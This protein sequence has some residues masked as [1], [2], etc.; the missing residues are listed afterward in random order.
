MLE[1]PIFLICSERAGSNLIRTIMN[2]HSH[3]YAPM[4]LHLIRII[5]KN[6]FQYG[7]LN[8]DKNWET[9]IKHTTLIIQNQVGKL[10]IEITVEELLN[11]I[12]QRTFQNIFEY[13]YAKGLK[14]HGKKRLFLKENQCY[15]FLYFLIHYFPD[16]K[17]VFQVRDP[18]DVVLS[19]KKSPLHGGIIDAINVWRNDQSASLEA[20]YTLTSQKIFVQRYEDLLENSEDVLKHLCSFLEIP[21]EDQ[22]LEF[23]QTPQSKQSAS[24]SIAWGNLQKPLLKD[25]YGKFKDGLITVEILLIEHQLRD[26][27]QQFG[28]K[29]TTE[30]TSIRVKVL[31]RLSKT[32]LQEYVNKYFQL[33][34]Q[35]QEV[36]KDE[37]DRRKKIAAI[38]QQISSEKKM[39]KKQGIFP[40]EEEHNR[41][42]AVKYHII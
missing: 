30:R 38:Y 29:V 9:L 28:Y 36:S 39:L 23:Y 19:M 33:G 32:G 2:T 42:R 40:K 8:S 27:M 13:I 7:D 20:F 17:F 34:M 10:D 21:F 4:P 25:N 41:L 15:K 3:I 24:L 26:L 14:K 12:S 22:M 11:N 31:S 35:E 6:I 5:W 1:K 37:I 16:A 18:R